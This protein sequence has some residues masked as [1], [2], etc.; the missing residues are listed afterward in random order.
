MWFKF[1]STLIVDN[2]KKK[3]NKFLMP[4]SKKQIVLVRERHEVGILNG[5]KLS[6]VCCNFS[7]YLRI[8]SVVVH[9]R[10]RMHENEACQH[11]WMLWL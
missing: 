10:I 11:A 5:S 8:L 6:K 4:V 2:K 9:F 7:M 1:K 3:I